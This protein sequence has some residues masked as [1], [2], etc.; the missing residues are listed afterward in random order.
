MSEEEKNDNKKYSS[1]FTRTPNILFASYKHLTKEEKFLYITLR[2][3]YWDAKPR[4]VSLRDLAAL[5]EYSTGALS[6]MLPRLTLV[7]LIHAEVRKEIDPKTKQEKGNS[8]YHITI[9]DI[10]EVNKHFYSCSPNERVDPSEILVHQMIQAC[11]PNDTSLF[12]KNDKPVHQMNKIVLD[13]E[14]AKI[15]KD[16][17]KDNFKEVGVDTKNVDASAPNIQPSLFSSEKS[18]T[19]EIPIATTTAKPIDLQEKKTAKEKRVTPEKPAPIELTPEIIAVLDAWDSIFTRPTPRTPKMIEAAKE[20][21][22]CKAT[23]DDLVAVR[24][25][26]YKSNPDWYRG[27]NIGVTLCSIVSNWS[28]WLSSQ[29]SNLQGTVK[30]NVPTPM[31]RPNLERFEASVAAGNPVFIELSVEDK[32]RLKPESRKIYFKFLKDEQIARNAAIYAA[33]RQVATV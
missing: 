10:W 24:N 23:R 1:D 16:T 7:G 32:N 21:A 2:C 20:L 4:Y 5:T 33:K 3:V 14:L 27:K 17:S 8:K 25:Y 22:S 29:D 11:S 12:T 19:Q 28:A 15:K 6:K 13:S 9:S 18:T 31:V 30:S 26:C